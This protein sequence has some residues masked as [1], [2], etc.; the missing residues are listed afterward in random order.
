MNDRLMPNPYE[1]PALPV[2]PRR[3]AAS[4]P[5]K[6]DRAAVGLPLSPRTAI[7]GVLRYWWQILGLWLVATA[8][9]AGYIYQKFKPTYEATSLLRIDPATQDPFA[10]STT[11]TP[12]NE[13]LLQTQVRLVSSSNVLSAAIADSKVSHF[14]LIRSS[15]DPV[16]TLRNLLEV[17]AL[18]KSFLIQ[19][20]MTTGSSEEASGLVNAIVAAY[21]KA[22]AEWSDSL[23]RQQFLRLESFRDELKSQVELQ[24]K[25]WLELAA[26]GNVD[27]PDTAKAGDAPN[28]R[29]IATIEEYK[30]LRDQLVEVKIDLAHAEAE[31]DFRRKEP[32]APPKAASSVEDRLRGDPDITALWK[33][34]EDAREKLV[35]LQ[36]RVRNTADP[37]VKMQRARLATLVE[38]QKILWNAKIKALRKEDEDPANREVD[39]RKRELAQAAT[40]VGALTATQTKL[41]SMIAQLDVA[42]RQQATDAVKTALIRADLEQTRGMLDLVNRR[43]EAIKFESR[44]LTR[45]ILIDKA[46]PA[47]SPASDKRPK[48]LAIVPFATLGALLGLF[49]LL[50]FRAGRITN[51]QDLTRRCHAEVH[52]IPMLPRR[53]T[54]SLLK[55]GGPS[56][57]LNE[58]I[59]EFS[60]RLDHLRVAL[61]D[62]ANRGRGRCLLITSAVGGE[63]K[64]TLAAQLASRCARSGATTLLIDGDLRRP[65]L[66]DL[67]EVPEGPGL[68]DVLNEEIAPQDAMVVIDRAGGFHLLPAG[69]TGT[70]PSKLFYGEKLGQ[71][72]ARCRETFDVVIIDAPP[73]LPVPDAL[74]LARHA[75]GVVLA[76]R[77]DTSRFPLF[78][79][80]QKLLAGAGIPLL[81]VVVNGV[82]Q[83]DM[84]IGGYAYQ[85]QPRPRRHDGSSA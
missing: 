43:L 13:N 44:S 1:P 46:R 37:S 41:E 3:P 5:Q 31:L 15:P 68:V 69:T 33:I 39:P 22:D 2:K 6:S 34:T 16:A 50:E 67:L 21:L 78:D 84:G 71:F 24:Q 56:R 85:Y 29:I 32:A 52:S 80:A 82:R 28:S 42:N 19:V 8:G 79:R 65:A 58:Q 70:D 54:G 40:K 66:V 18:P 35:L 55:M 63:G 10:A 17:K 14:G 36:N 26:K 27:T 75:D 61:C 48:M 20:S 59:E 23:T 72:L 7:R 11:F 57:G 77:Q 83:N 60:C 76:T 12:G 51:P 49:T 64:T 45:I 9:A 74:I 25:A 38:Q 30:R 4:S 81:G 62:D 47:A 53:P 73:V